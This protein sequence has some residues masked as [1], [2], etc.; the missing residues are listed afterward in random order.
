MRERDGESEDKS[1]GVRT[2]VITTSLVCI[3]WAPSLATQ[4][5]KDFAIQQTRRIGL[6][7][8]L[9]EHTCSMSRLSACPAAKGRPPEPSSSKTTARAIPRGEK[10]PSI[11]P[12]PSEALPIVHPTPPKRGRKGDTRE[13]RNRKKT[14]S[15]RKSNLSFAVRQQPHSPMVGVL[16]VDRVQPSTGM[17]L[18]RSVASC[19]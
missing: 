17:S 7:V 4:E 13:N 12:R 14:K 5:G 10:V 8:S 9:L 15:E 18:A 3:P 6:P 11:L 16:R 1:G 2:R 19:S